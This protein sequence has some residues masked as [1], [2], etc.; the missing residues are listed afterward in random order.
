M[1]AVRTAKPDESKKANMSAMISRRRPV[2]SAALLLT[3]AS[4]AAGTVLSTACSDRGDSP[5]DAGAVES[6]ADATARHGGEDLV[7]IPPTDAQ[8]DARNDSSPS[9]AAQD[10]SSDAAPTEA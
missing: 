2:V 9:D 7:S 4:L 5:A 8:A 10:R 6:G 3:C 1:T